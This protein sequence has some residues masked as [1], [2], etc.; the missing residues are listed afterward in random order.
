MW[1][2]QVN[3]RPNDRPKETERV[4]EVERKSF[5]IELKQ[6]TANVMSIWAKTF[7]KYF[8]EIAEENWKPEKAYT[9]AF[10]MCA[11]GHLKEGKG[12]LFTLVVLT[13]GTVAVKNS[14]QKQQQQEQQH[15]R[16]HAK[17]ACFF[18]TF[19]ALVCA[20]RISNLY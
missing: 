20:A 3:E 9:I 15:T 4:R 2:E 1:E 14:S 8:G 7:Y 13:T 19:F 6:T 5:Q 16:N 12:R 18:V 17:F 11:S 10:F